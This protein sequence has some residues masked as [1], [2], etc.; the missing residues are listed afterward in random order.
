MKYNELPVYDGVWDKCCSCA[1]A[2]QPGEVFTLADDGNLAFCYSDGD[3]GCLQEY[4]FYKMQPSRTLFGDPH[5]F[6]VRVAEPVA[7]APV[8]RPRR[9]WQ[10]WR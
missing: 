8:P 7:A 4:R 5:V 10:F 1:R 9:W 2:F 3:G 6:R